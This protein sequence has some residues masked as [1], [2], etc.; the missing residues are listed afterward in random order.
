MAAA[1]AAATERSRNLTAHAV[2]VEA[3]V[4]KPTAFSLPG[5]CPAFFA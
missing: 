4:R 1:V 2:S 5:F 3:V